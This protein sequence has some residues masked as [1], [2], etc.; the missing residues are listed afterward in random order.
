MLSLS[1]QS[2][3]WL[4]LMAMSILILLI[5][6][7][8]TAVNIAMV[9]ISEEIGEDLNTLQWLLSAYVLTWA[10]FVIPAGQLADIYGKR[11]VLLAGITTFMLASILCGL[12]SSS[13]ALIFARIL[14]GFGGALF[15]P[16]LYALCFEFFP[17]DKRG[18]AIGI[19]GVG[20]GIGLAIGPSFGGFLLNEWGWRWIFLINGPLCFI[21][22]AT[23]MLCVPQETP[24]RANQKIDIVGSFFLISALVTGLYSLNQTE[25]WGLADWR[26]WA[27][28]TV[29]VV[30][31]GLLIHSMKDKPHR[32]IPKGLFAN[33]AF[34][35]T[36]IG[37]SFY[38]FS[39]SVVLVVIGLFIQ[40]VLGYSAYEAGIIFL[41]M[42]ISLGILSPLGGKLTDIMD[43]RIPI[44]G[45][46][47]LLA[48]ALLAC[49]TLTSESSLTIVISILFLIGLG[50]G[51][52]F[53]ALNATMMKTVDP[54]ILSTASGTF[55]MS[56]CAFNATGVVVSTSVLVGLGRLFMD[57]M[58]A[59]GSVRV[60][61]K[62]YSALIDFLSKAYRNMELF[63]HKTPEETVILVDYVNQAFTQ[64]M[65]WIMLL[66]STMI[67]LAFWACLTMI[68]LKR[69][70][71]ESA[72][73][74]APRPI[75]V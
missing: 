36:M 55:I 20:A 9:K 32:L 30:F 23:V 6:I 67:A 75:A 49:S 61:E 74:Q 4:A 69:K 2:R 28:F 21:C 29:S 43:A 10:A 57:K 68:R 11:R 15:V 60:D 38:S 27:L 46:L 44:C 63:N 41:A 73:E 54:S 5:N 22:I 70:A 56:C 19:L 3:A 51:I 71:S 53:P 8:Y 62:T 13:P 52:A 66:T 59:V 31:V 39:F 37:F 7:D 26:I 40:N 34:L 33:R 12:V 65:M 58:I 1:H 18:L 45:G 35:G 14:Q 72:E 16:P 17:E 42:T 50:M 47:A 64:S 25:V 48:L 24:E